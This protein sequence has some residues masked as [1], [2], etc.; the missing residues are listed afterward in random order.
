MVCGWLAG[1]A[2]LPVFGRLRVSAC[3]VDWLGLPLVLV[4]GLVLCLSLHVLLGSGFVVS[5]RS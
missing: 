2:W 5:L 3:H 4:Q 1:L